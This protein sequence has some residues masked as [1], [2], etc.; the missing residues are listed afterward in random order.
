MS[1][2]TLITPPASHALNVGRFEDYRDFLKAVFE[3]RKSS[4]QRVSYEWLARR[5]KLSKTHVHDILRKKVHASLEG[6]AAICRALKVEAYEREALLLNL[7]AL[8]STDE[9][10]SEFFRRAG[11]D[12][13]LRAPGS[14]LLSIQRLISYDPNDLER[15]KKILHDATAECDRLDKSPRTGEEVHLVSLQLQLMSVAQ[16]EPGQPKS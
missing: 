8:T 2:T 7:L 14:P 12:M 15:I 5:A 9:D 11:Q 13:R 6:L 1:Q 3:T 16:R 10:V 4:M